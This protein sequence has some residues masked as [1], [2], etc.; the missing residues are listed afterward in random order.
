MPNAN[1][2]PDNMDPVSTSR[3]AVEIV[4]AS[5]WGQIFDEADEA[6]RTNRKL[7]DSTDADTF[8]DTRL[9][10]NRGA[11]AAWAIAERKIAAVVL[12]T[13]NAIAAEVD[14]VSP[15]MAMALRSNDPDRYARECGA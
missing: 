4:R 8:W 11:C 15:A 7:D 1:D 6:L 2:L 5:R 14:A 9:E 3:E 13:L 10:A 12:E